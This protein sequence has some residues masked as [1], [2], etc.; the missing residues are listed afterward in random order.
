LS[1]ELLLAQFANLVRVQLV[2]PR[3]RQ[4]SKLGF[5]KLLV[6]I[7]VGLG[8]HLRREHHTRPKTA[9]STRATWAAASARATTWSISA[10][11]WHCRLF[12]QLRDREDKRAFFALAGNNDFAVLAALEHC[13]EAVETQIASVSFL[14]V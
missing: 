8:K 11:G 6:G 2:E 7:F 10:F 5:S 13:L 9:A 4:S 12:V 1:G 14:A 3:L